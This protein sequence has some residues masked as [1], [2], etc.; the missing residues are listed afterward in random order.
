MEDVSQSLIKVCVEQEDAGGTDANTVVVHITPLTTERLHP[1]P[2][3]QWDRDLLTGFG[4][5]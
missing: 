3:T 2:L 4:S 1:S 5:V